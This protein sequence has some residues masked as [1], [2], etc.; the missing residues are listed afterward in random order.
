MDDYVLA[1]KEREWLDT[2]LPAVQNRRPTDV[3]SS[4]KLRDLIVEFQRLREGQ[5]I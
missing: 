1:P 5:P 3:I 2:P 4:G